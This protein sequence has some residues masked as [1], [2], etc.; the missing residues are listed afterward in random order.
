MDIVKYRDAFARG[1]ALTLDMTYMP[2]DKLV[3]GVSFVPLHTYVKGDPA[4][5]GKQCVVLG[6]ERAGVYTGKLN[7][8]GGKIEDKNM[9]YRGEDVAKVL[10]EEV[11][12]ELHLVLTPALFGDML[13]K[14]LTVPFNDGVTLVFVVHLKGVSRSVWDAEHSARCQSQTPW[15][16]V[17]FDNIE[18]VPITKLLTRKDLSAFVQIVA[19]DILPITEKLSVNKGVHCGKF[20]TAEVKKGGKVTVK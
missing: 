7:F 15:K 3:Y 9:R 4:L 10:F 18:H 16:Y 14:V 17:E 13:L 6:C 20:L 8:V 5:V 2:M 19:K 1:M 12:E 11:F